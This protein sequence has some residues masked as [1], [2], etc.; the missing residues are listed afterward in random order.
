MISV[1]MQKGNNIVEMGDEVDEAMARLRPLLPPDLKLD[2]I[3]NQPKV[4]QE[5]MAGMGHEFFI[6]IVCVIL[7]TVILLPMRVAVIA[8]LAIPA[9][10]LTTLGVMD[11]MG[12]RCTRCPSPP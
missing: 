7:V 6:A 4:V 11:A 1:E 5:R 12:L 9:T 2:Y 10:M 8:A 3:A